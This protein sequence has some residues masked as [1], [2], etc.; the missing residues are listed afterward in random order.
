MHSPTLLARSLALPL[1]A[2]VT[3]EGLELSPQAGLRVREDRRQAVG[4]AAHSRLGEDSLLGAVALANPALFQIIVETADS[5]KGSH[6]RSLP[7]L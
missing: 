7:T 3:N 5:K 6:T 1:S 2:S 4:M